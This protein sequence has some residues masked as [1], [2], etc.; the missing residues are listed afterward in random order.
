[1]NSC[2]DKAISQVAKFSHVE[3]IRNLQNFR[4][5]QK[6][7]T[8]ENFQVAK[9]SQPHSFSSTLCFSFL[10]VFDLLV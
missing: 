5:L 7:T 1:M 6:V 2:N 10:W 3:K 4:R 9:I 8:C